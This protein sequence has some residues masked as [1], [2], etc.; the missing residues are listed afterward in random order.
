VK[1]LTYS[2]KNLQKMGIRSL[3]KREAVLQRKGSRDRREAT[4][5][6]QTVDVSFVTGMTDPATQAEP[7]TA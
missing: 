3:P 2:Q 1:I 7:I 6:D 4:A 5:N